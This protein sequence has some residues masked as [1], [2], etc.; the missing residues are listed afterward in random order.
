MII[1]S[2][3]DWD[4]YIY[5]DLHVQTEGKMQNVA[6][7]LCGFCGEWFFLVLLFCFFFYIWFDS[8]S[9]G[10]RCY[11]PKRKAAP[12]PSR[13]CSISITLSAARV[14]NFNGDLTAKSK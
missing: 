8:V 5:Q 6:A 2:Q 10:R 12:F 7:N 9:V 11:L 1:T 4:T 13:D 3:S 14:G